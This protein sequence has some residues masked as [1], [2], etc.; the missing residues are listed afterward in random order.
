MANHGHRAEAPFPF[1][2][3]PTFPSTDFIRHSGSICSI[4]CKDEADKPD[5]TGEA[6]RTKGSSR[7]PA[8]GKIPL[9]QDVFMPF[10]R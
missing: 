5:S 4:A 7:G 9:F 2:Y 1:V 10:M 8:I 6:V 3:A